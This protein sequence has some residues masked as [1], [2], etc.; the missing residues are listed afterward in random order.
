MPTAGPHRQRDLLSDALPEPPVV[1]PGGLLLRDLG[2]GERD[3]L[4]G[5]SR[6]Y[7]PLHPLQQGDPVDPGGVVDPAGPGGQTA[8]CGQHLR[9]IAGHGVTA[10]PALLGPR[11]HRRRHTENATETH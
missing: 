8:D 2:A 11:S 7:S 6:R 5:L 9:Q 10:E 4:G 3:D 1:D